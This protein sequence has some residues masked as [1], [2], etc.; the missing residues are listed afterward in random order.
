VGVTAAAKRLI[1]LCWFA[2]RASDTKIETTDAYP[3]AVAGHLVES[4][5]IASLH[6]NNDC[7]ERRIG[8]PP[9]MR[10]APTPLFLSSR[11][12]RHKV[13]EIRRRLVRDEPHLAL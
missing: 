5:S 2:T 6:S 7:A 13:I 10:V 4:L 8:H 11:L 12:I 9:F 1:E 3:F